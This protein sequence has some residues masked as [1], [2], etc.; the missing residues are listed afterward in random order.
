M[1]LSKV[2]ENICN[3][4]GKENLFYG[5]LF[6]ENKCSVNLTGVSETDRVIVDLDKVFPGG[7]RGKKQCEC[8]LFYIDAATNFIVVPIELKG[9]KNTETQKAVKQLKGGA[10]FAEK[11]LPSG[12]KCIC[13]PL[14]FHKKNN[15]ST[16]DFSYLKR[17]T[18]KVVL[19]GNSFE[20]K[21][22]HCGA[23]LAKVLP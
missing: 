2:L 17:K 18:S 7:Q 11:Y 6:E 14:L 22:A 1:K 4:V 20:I 21:T 13:R 9:G 12:Y 10:A 15:M 19:G 5:N 8:V 16:A 3:Q 23:K